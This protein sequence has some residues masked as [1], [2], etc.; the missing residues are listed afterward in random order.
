MICAFGAYTKLF[1][2]LKKEPKIYEACVWLGASSDSGDN[3][4]IKSVKHISALNITEIKNAVA[5]LQGKVEY[6]PPKY[7][8]KHIDGTRAYK[9]AR[10]G[11]DFELKKEQMEIFSAKILHYNHPFL[12]VE[13][14]VSTGSY[15]R[16][17]A[18]LLADRLGVDA[19]LSALERKAEGDF[20]F[21]DERALN[22][23]DFLAIPK[24]EYF[25]EQRD[26]EIGKKLDISSFKEQKNGLYLICFK[27]FFSIIEI[28]EA[29]V[30]YRLN[31]IKYANLNKK[32][33]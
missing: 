5:S 2:Y 19:T 1:L 6:T 33:K 22:P 25:G 17:W 15:I 20:V 12:L 32:E 21:D 28:F 18:Q 14:K 16:S 9:L 26:F 23:L 3:E 10:S 4:N 24:N 31:G 30:K 7:S 11:M 8:A 13:L 27:D 29:E